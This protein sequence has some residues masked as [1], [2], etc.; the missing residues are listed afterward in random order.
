MFT[1]YKVQ[2]QICIY[3]LDL[4]SYSYIHRTVFPIIL[5]FIFIIEYNDISYSILFYLIS[6]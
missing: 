5:F 4:K 1:Y 2:K 3:A 6:A